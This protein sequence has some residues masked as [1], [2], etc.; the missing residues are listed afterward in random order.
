M[1]FLSRI[2]KPYKKVAFIRKTC[3]QMCRAQNLKLQISPQFLPLVNFKSFLTETIWKEIANQT[4]LYFLITILV[5]L[6]N[7]AEHKYYTAQYTSTK[8]PQY[9]NPECQT[10]LQRA[11]ESNFTYQF[12]VLLPLQ[13]KSLF[14]NLRKQT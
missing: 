10:G 12:L 7:L 3:P 2:S 11:A 4:D 6:C 13:F 8:Q 5:I 9:Y 1:K 14:N